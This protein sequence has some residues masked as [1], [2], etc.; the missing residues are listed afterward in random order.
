MPSV[1]IGANTLRGKP[2]RFRDILSQAGFDLI[3]PPGDHTLGDDEMRQY[4]PQCSASIAGGEN[5]TDALMRQCPH[6]RVIAR[7]GVG[8][9]CVDVAAA[10]RLGVAVAITPGTNHDAVA[11]QAFALLLAI[12][13]RITIN[14]RDV[15]SGGWDRTLPMPLRAKTLGLVG[16]GRIG[17]A[18]V[19][20]AQAFLM[21]VIAHD[22]L[23]PASPQ[24]LAAV[25]RVSFDDLLAT[26]DVISIHC[27]LNQETRGWFDQSVFSRM[28]RGSILLNTA[29]G[30]IINEAHLVAAI[31]S[32]HLA[33]AG[34]DVLENEP[35]NPD[36][37][38]LRLDQ[39]VISPHIAGIDTLSMAD[40]A[41]KAAWIV[42]EIAA[43]RRP[44]DCIVNP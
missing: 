17:R 6:L 41:D 10:S 7:T 40:M 39:V 34:L 33:G 32:G 20:R 23:A 15:R 18:M 36:N 42:A 31:Q 8:Y 30:P 4:L 14:D 19:A 3:D 28:R 37:P 1:L 25:P 44:A 11:E 26:S 9:D 27:P 21:N 16:L 2:G 29:R 43:G 5:Y 22:T 24:D 38:L 13:R 12:T 35:T